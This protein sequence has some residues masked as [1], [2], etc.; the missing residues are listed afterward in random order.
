VS[1]MV[2]PGCGAT[3][4]PGTTAL[5]VGA[6]VVCGACAALLVVAETGS[7]LTWPTFGQARRFHD[8]PAVK[9]ALDV[10]R[11]RSRHARRL[12]DRDHGWASRPAP[13]P[14]GRP[15]PVEVSGSTGAPDPSRRGDAAP[16]G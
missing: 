14:T 7:R 5:T 11:G 8:D 3:A 10:A 2:C 6:P 15:P 13:T 4:A 1:A 16:P 9:A 12:R